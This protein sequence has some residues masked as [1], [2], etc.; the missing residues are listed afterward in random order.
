M[1][2]RTFLT[3]SSV[4]GLVGLAG[5][6]GS[7]PSSDTP[8]QSSTEAP[9]QSNSQPAKQSGSDPSRQSAA[10]FETPDALLT[11]LYNRLAGMS[12]ADL[13]HNDVQAS[14]DS[15]EVRDV[16]TNV[17]RENIDTGRLAGLVDLSQAEVRSV[18]DGADT[19]IGRVRVQL[20]RGTSVDEIE[21]SWALATE[22]ENWQ[23]VERVNSTASAMLTKPSTEFEFDYR[24]EENAVTITPT[25]GDRVPASD[26]IVTGTQMPL[27]SVGRVHLL[28][29]S[30]YSAEERIEHGRAIEV[31]V[32]S[33]TFEIS[34]LWQSDDE[35]CECRLA[36]YTGPN[37]K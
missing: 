31:T 24:S 20:D 2:R 14:G 10:T 17:L 16:R 21:E 13:V 37:F 34:V 19:A 9:D 1:E 33:D 22:G 29:G 12:T 7:Q 23:V 28:A 35:S 26:L 36:H 27:D 32:E 11:E 25:G 4:A 5:C 6:A 3:R 18:T 8:G 30:G 15:F